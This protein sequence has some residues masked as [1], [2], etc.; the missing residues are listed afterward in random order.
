MRCLSC[1]Q[2]LD[3]L[4]LEIGQWTCTACSVRHGRDS[5]AAKTILAVGRTVN[6]C[7]ER[8]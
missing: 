3:A 2:V 7:A 5:N 8:R 1:G 6:A 4:P